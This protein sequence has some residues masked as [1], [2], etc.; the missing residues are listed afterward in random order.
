[1]EKKNKQT[2]NKMKIKKNTLNNKDEQ[3]SQNE[4]KT[5]IIGLLF[6]LPNSYTI[7]SNVSLLGLFEV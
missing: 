6:H 5:T 7:L 1:M 2:S 3:G 4:F